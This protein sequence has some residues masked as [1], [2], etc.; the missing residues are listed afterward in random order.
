VVAGSVDEQHAEAGRLG[1]AIRA[2]FA[3]R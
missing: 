3:G 2:G 1:S